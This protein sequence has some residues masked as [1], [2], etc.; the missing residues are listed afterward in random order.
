MQIEIKAI[1]LSP[2][3]DFRGRTEVGRLEHGIQPVN[4]VEC[5][6]GSGLVGDRYFDF[7][8]DYKGQVTFFDWA[9]YEDIK[10][11]FDCPEIEPWVF[12]R[13]ILTAGVDL[14]ALIGQNF[15]IQGVEFEGSEEAAPCHWMDKVVRPGVHEALK[16]FGGLRARI[17]KSGTLGCSDAI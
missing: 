1:F 3:H 5:I 4:S 2:G 8:D 11:R 10:K 16:G 15:T 7:K 9:V 17:R 12:R 14:N 13:N 6:A